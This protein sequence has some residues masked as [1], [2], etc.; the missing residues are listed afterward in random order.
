MSGALAG[1]LQ[2]LIRHSVVKNA[3]L[4]YGVQLS[5]YIFP[6]V[7]LPYLSRVLNPSKF[8]LVAFAQSFIWYFVT[9]TEYGFN[10]TATRRIAIHA[11]DHEL[12]QQAAGANAGR[13]IAIKR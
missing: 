5:S 1:R 4:L 11:D 2:K 10:L 3:M 6:L 8:G 12:F 13:V 7:A 9:L